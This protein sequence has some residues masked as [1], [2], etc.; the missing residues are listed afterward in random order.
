LLRGD[1]GFRNV[2]VTRVANACRERGPLFQSLAKEARNE[3]SAVET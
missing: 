3:R 1:P 2:I